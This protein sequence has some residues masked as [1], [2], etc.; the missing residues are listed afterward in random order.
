MLDLRDAARYELAVRTTERRRLPQVPHLMAPCVLRCARR[1]R[2]GRC[3]RFKP[4]RTALLPLGKET[5]EFV[6]ALLL[7]TEH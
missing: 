6:A 7:L 1:R 3:P 5:G 4:L 2:T